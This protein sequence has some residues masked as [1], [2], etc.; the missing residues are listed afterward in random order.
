MIMGCA[1]LS[2][3]KLVL[4]LNPRDVMD[5]CFEDNNKIHSS[6]I[7]KSNKN[8]HNILVVDDSMVHRQN[9]RMILTRAG[10]NV[11]ESENGF[12]ALK[13][14]RLKKYT[15]L[16]VDV[17]MPLMDGI[18]LTRRLRNLPLYR[19]IPILLITSKHSRED[20]AR[21]IKSGANEYFE[22]PI[23]ADVLL[24]AINRYITERETV[25]K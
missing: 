25:S 20:R 3:R 8:I 22:K 17:V 24:S 14:V 16:C 13:M 2:D 23:D 7:T 15:I 12:E 5:A 21:G 10:Y 4:V 1:I 11:D 9:V 19:S 6:E 18:E